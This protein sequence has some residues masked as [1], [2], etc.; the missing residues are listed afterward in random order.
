M[1]CIPLTKLESKDVEV[2]KLQL[3]LQVTQTLLDQTKTELVEVYEGQDQLLSDISTKVSKELCQTS[4]WSPFF[5]NSNNTTTTVDDDE[6]L[7]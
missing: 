7:N 1:S 2:K 4:W 5:G 3:E 6:Q